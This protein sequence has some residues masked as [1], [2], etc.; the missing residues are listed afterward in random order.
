MQHQP[1]AD[2]Y[3]ALFGRYRQDFGD[4]YLGPPDDRYRLIFEQVCHMLKQPSPFNLSLPVP[5][6]ATAL[7]YLAGD[8]PTLAHMK[9]ADNRHFMLSDLFDYIHLVSTMGG[10]WGQ[11]G[12]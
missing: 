5:F 4:V 10:A 2:A 7:R 11:R 8:P 6:R 1:D 12:R 3:L 9:E